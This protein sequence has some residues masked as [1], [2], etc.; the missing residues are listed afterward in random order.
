MQKGQAWRQRRDRDPERAQ[1]AIKAA[2]VASPLAW[3]GSIRYQS[4]CS[5]RGTYLL[6]ALSASAKGRICCGFV[7][8][9]ACRACFSA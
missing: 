8:P 2:R 1:S 6:S 7:A 4:A 9:T 3:P 5:A